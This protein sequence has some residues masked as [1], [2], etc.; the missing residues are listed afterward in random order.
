MK[1]KNLLTSLVALFLLSG[2]NHTATSSENTDSS[3]ITESSTSSG[4]ANDPV[5]SPKESYGSSSS[6]EKQ[7]E[8]NSYFIT[9]K[10]VKGGSV[11]ADPQLAKKCTLV[12]LQVNTEDNYVLDGF[13]SN[14]EVEFNEVEEG[15]LYS[16]VMPE[17][18]IEITP[19]FLGLNSLKLINMASDM[20]SISDEDSIFQKKY[21][22]GSIVSFNIVG[23]ENNS[24]LNEDIVSHIYVHVGKETYHP[25]LDKDSGNA[26]IFFAMP[27]KNESVYIIYS[28]QKEED[29]HSLTLS[30]STGFRFLG[31]DD[32]K[33]YSSIDCYL[34]REEG[35]ML[36]SLAWKYDDEETWHDISYNFKSRNLSTC[37]VTL[38]GGFAKDITLK[39]EGLFAGKKVTYIN[40]SD[41][42]FL[43]GRI[44]STIYDTVEAPTLFIPGETYDFYVRPI[45]G[46]HLK[47][48]TF[49][50]IN[51]ESPKRELGDVYNIKFTMPDNDVT[52]QYECADNGK[53][54]IEDNPA[55]ASAIAK[56]AFYVSEPGIDNLAPGKTF[57]VVIEAKPGYIINGAKLN[58]GELQ[59][60]ESKTDYNADGYPKVNFVK[61][62]MPDSGNATITFEAGKGFAVDS[63]AEDKISFSSS[64]KSTYLEGDIVKFS[65]NPGALYK[66][67]DVKVVK[68]DDEN[69]EVA[70]SFDKSKPKPYSFAM[71]AYDVRIKVTKEKVESKT[72]SLDFS[73]IDDK[74]ISYLAVKF[75]KLD[76][77]VKYS[78]DNTTSSVECPLDETISATI[79]SIDASKEDV[80]EATYDDDSKKTFKPTKYSLSSYSNELEFSYDKIDVGSNLKRLKF[81]MSEMKK[82]SITIID[83]TGGAISYSIKVNSK[84]VASAPKTLYLHQ[85]VTITITKKDSNDTNVYAPYINGT[86]AKISGKNFKFEVTEEETKIEFKKDQAYTLQVINNSTSGTFADYDEYEEMDD[87]YSGKT[88]S[89]SENTKRTFEIRRGGSINIDI[90]VEADGVKAE[91]LSKNDTKYLMLTLTFNKNYKVTITDHA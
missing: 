14:P 82:S 7:E 69:T 76:N 28:N 46:K 40:S 65:V 44:G 70:L 77:T 1:H 12:S 79:S 31:I 47:E 54:V 59:K 30:A 64:G 15:K 51:L 60:I 50:G 38:D 39:A 58:G 81:M 89:F 37:K 55:I 84:N 13:T 27:K 16:F 20:I 80:I 91:S 3:S 45:A 33:K 36:S 18:N 83:S 9:V 52:I 56:S 5:S 87:T 61:F 26:T 6:E 21:K 32:K 78:K 71:P 4:K 42:E 10:E 48:I 8:E 2:C 53:I 22:E 49:T 57:Y 11:T 63:S 24:V 34:M 85:I 90:L 66:V 35:Y 74:A 41:V 75:Q 62:T 23:K 86:K 19:S 88:T 43:K 68:A 67:T 72:I 29:G 73:E 17:D 25:T